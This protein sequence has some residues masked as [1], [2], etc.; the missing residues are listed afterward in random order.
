MKYRNLLNL[1]HELREGANIL[2]K[3]ERLADV[4]DRNSDPVVLQEYGISE[5]P[6]LTVFIKDHY[7][8]ELIQEL[9][10]KYD[11]IV[12]GLTFQERCNRL[13]DAHYSARRSACQSN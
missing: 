13:L 9:Q 11:V 6:S 5:Q 12:S 1:N 8:L 2:Y 7:D 3:I 10:S 4:T